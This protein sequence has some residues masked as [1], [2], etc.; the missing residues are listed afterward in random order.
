MSSTEELAAV[1][2]ICNML[3][4]RAARATGRGRGDGDVGAHPVQRMQH[5]A[6]R[7]LHPCRRGR[8]G[9]DQADA[10]GQA[11]RDEARL[12]H[13]AAQLRKRQPLH[14]HRIRRSEQPVVVLRVAQQLVAFRPDQHLAVPGGCLPVGVSRAGGDT[15]GG[16]PAD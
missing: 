10:H 5:R 3:F 11:E 9:D 12:P 6:L 4:A 8:Y 15:H 1:E 16:L 7:V 14:A 13:P 2:R